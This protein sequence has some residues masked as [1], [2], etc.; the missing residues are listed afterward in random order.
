VSEESVRD[1]LGQLAGASTGSTSF[2]DTRG[3]PIKCKSLGNLLC[4]FSRSPPDVRGMSGVNRLRLERVVRAK[5]RTDSHRKLRPRNSRC[6]RRLPCCRIATS[7]AADHRQDSFPFARREAASKA[8]PK[9]QHPNHRY[10]WSERMVCPRP[11]IL[12]LRSIGRSPKPGKLAINGCWQ[13][14]SLAKRAK[15]PSA[16]W[17]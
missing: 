4:R 9:P 14:I 17:V 3:G 11:R 6:L 5:K 16:A 1:K 13:G 12:S 8:P 15:H 2:I 10:V 7:R